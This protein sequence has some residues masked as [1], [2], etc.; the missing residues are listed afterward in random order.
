M[1]AE[2]TAWLEIRASVGRG[3][4]D[5]K[6]GSSGLASHSLE[7]VL[8]S[9]PLPRM[10][11]L[12]L[13]HS[14]GASSHDPGNAS[15]PPLPSPL[16]EKPLQPLGSRPLWTSLCV[17]LTLPESGLPDGISGRTR[18]C[19]RHSR[20]RFDPWPGKIPWRK[21]WQRP[22]HWP[23][24]ENPTDRGAWKAAAHGSRRVGHD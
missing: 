16:T 10:P 21:A 17:I 7:P 12:C 14:P 22:L 24:L 5:E 6:R 19:R 3:D 18:Q 20:R 2:G 4:T 13:P 9:S 1:G 23:C 11:S 15:G 8:G